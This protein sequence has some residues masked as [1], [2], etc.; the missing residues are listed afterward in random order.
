MIYFTADLHFGHANVIR[1]DDRPFKSVEE[2]DEALIERWNN[3][4]T[5]E[6]TVYVLGDISWY[7]DEKTC[8]ILDRL[9][10]RK[11]LIQGNHDR[12]HGKM[13]NFFDEICSYKEIVIGENTHVVLCHYPI[14][15]FN[16]HHYGAYMLYG[17][18]HNSYEWQMT[19]KYKHEL[20]Q[21]GV[22][23]NMFNAGCMVHN[24]EPVTLEE[25]IKQ[26][27]RKDD[28]ARTL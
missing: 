19:E 28:Y 26:D 16:R 27:E 2:M 11:I 5:D 21:N 23:C 10:G 7:N 22:I 15:F 25:I 4:V 3:K 17:H 20:Q 12:V 9:R 1:F 6:D 14:V 13:R 18:V 8:S 24:Y